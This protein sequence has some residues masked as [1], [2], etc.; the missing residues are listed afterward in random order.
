[1]T[2]MCIRITEEE[3]AT[4]INALLNYECYWSKKAEVGSYGRASCLHIA[5][6]ANELFKKLSG[7]GLMLP[8]I[9]PASPAPQTKPS[10]P[11]GG[12]KVTK[13]TPPPV[14]PL[15]GVAINPRTGREFQTTQ[16]DINF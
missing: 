1:M 4:I 10:A 14:K 6:E 8:A 15:S 2:T 11:S 3:R 13:P 12:V 16:Q 9:I 5:N 7:I